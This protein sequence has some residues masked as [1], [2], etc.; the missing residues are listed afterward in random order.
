VT[1][2]KP[3]DPVF[4]WLFFQRNAILSLPFENQTNLSGLLMVC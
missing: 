2:Q 1:I 3:D 4:E